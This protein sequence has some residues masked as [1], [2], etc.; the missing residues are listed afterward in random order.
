MLRI[1]PHR[2]DRITLALYQGL[3]QD[4]LSSM[5]VL[6]SMFHQSL[7][8]GSVLSLLKVCSRVVLPDICKLAYVVVVLG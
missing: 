3:P 7:G 2:E 6:F 4:H 1:S 8:K 5:L